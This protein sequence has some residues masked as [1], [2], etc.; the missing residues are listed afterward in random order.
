MNEE[1]ISTAVDSISDLYIST[2]K[3]FV[4]QKDDG[5]YSHSNGFSS[6]LTLG[7]EMIKNHLLDKETIG[8]FSTE[9]YTKFVTL[10]VDCKP[11]SEEFRREVVLTLKDCIVDFKIPQEYIYTSISGNKGYHV[12]IFLNDMT[13]ISNIVK[14]YEFI[15]ES[16]NL[17]STMIELRP[18]Y[19]MAV[20]LPLG[21]HRLTS[22]KCWFVD[23]YFNPIEDIDYV[24]SILQFDRNEFQLLVN[25][26]KMSSDVKKKMNVVYTEFSDNK[27]PM[28]TIEKT[29]KLEEV[30]LTESS[31]RN[32][33]SLQLGVL[34]NTLGLKQEDALI[35]LNDW[36]KNQDCRYFKTPIDLCAYEN[37]KILSW[38]YRNN[39][40]FTSK[41][42]DNIKLYKREVDWVS[43]VTDK[44][45]RH[46]L[47]V[48]LCHY[49]RYNNDIGKTFFMTHSQIVKNSTIKSKSNISKIIKY[50]EANKYLSIIRSGDYDK[51]SQMYNTN[52]Y[53]LNVSTNVFD[54]GKLVYTINDYNYSYMNDVSAL[55]NLLIL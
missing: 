19:T 20:K 41:Q 44:K 36:I 31:T 24:S 9:K 10:D 53:K 39:I 29:L 52:I 50:L 32:Y 18:S 54:K 21:T 4:R 30:G 6:K 48:L 34:Y 16:S 27:I 37:G 55:D 49:K 22:N 2:R 1:N 3:K 51:T 17:S 47:Y 42:N 7:N 15:L 38:V 25:G 8:I 14:F 33:S 28:M 46:L 13:P 11:Y 40:I 45:A 12:T 23:N 26:I 43:S 35:R 5:S